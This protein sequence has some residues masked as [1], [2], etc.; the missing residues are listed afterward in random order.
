MRQNFETCPMRR[1]QTHD[2]G[3]RVSTTTGDH[4]RNDATKDV[5]SFKLPFNY[6]LYVI[7]VRPS[8]R[9]DMVWFASLGVTGKMK[10]VS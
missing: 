6:N 8:Y 3:L 10:D 5:A 1:A 9:M 2:V 7:G 4:K